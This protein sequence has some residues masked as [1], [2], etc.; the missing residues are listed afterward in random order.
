[1]G[2]AMPAC[3]PSRSPLRSRGLEHDLGGA[4]RGPSDG[5]SS[6]GDVDARGNPAGDS[7]R[8]PIDPNPRGGLG[9]DACARRGARPRQLRDPRGAAR[10]AES[11]RGELVLDMSELEFIDSTGIAL[12]VATHRRLNGEGDGAGFRLVGSERTAVRRV[13]ALTGLDAELP[14][15]ETAA[16][17]LRPEPAGPG[18]RP[19]RERSPPRSRSRAAHPN[20]AGS[21]LS[22]DTAPR[23]AV[24]WPSSLAAFPAEPPS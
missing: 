18:C 11:R 17:C 2:R 9:P 24:S 12:L 13:M 16:R 22:F 3:R 21:R 1:M 7:G 14:S 20:A 4:L 6:L 19:A 23:S 8:D 10:E 15:G 5:R